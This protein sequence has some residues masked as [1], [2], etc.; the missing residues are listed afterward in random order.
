M[1]LSN[2]APN[3]GAKTRDDFRRGRGHGSGNGKTAGKGH[4]GQKA[5]SGAPRPGFEGGQMPLFRRIPKRGFKCRNSK[6]IIAINVSDLNRFDDNAVVTVDALKEVLKDALYGE[7]EVIGNK[8]VLVDTVTEKLFGIFD[9]AAEKYHNFAIELPMTIDNCAKVPTYAHDTDAA[10]DIYA[11][12]DIT[13]DAHS[14]GNKIR[15][16]VKIQLPEGWLA[17]II[18]RSSIGAKTPLRLS[19]SVGLIDSG[20]RGELG[21]LYD[22]VSDE[23]WEIHAGDRIA[24]LLVMPSY[25]FLADVVDTLTDSDRGDGGFGS[26]GT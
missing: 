9:L 15:T 13:L 8:K 21:V 6:Y 18:P 1:D 5:R 11:L 23:P 14:F 22:N 26:S 25:R 7:V 24:Q 19:N 2:L 12:E 10:A 4:K 17:L 20:Y 16:G 3:A